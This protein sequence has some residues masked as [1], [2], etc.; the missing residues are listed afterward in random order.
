[1]YPITSYIEPK[2][3]L[4]VMLSEQFLT[5]VRKA[6][7]RVK[8]PKLNLESLSQFILA[9]P[10]RA[11]Q[12]RIVEKVEKLLALC[13]SLKCWLTNAKAIQF[14]LAD[15]TADQAAQLQ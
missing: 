15:A 5:Q 9:V 12:R 7:N 8:M 10:P 3:M 6:E 1:M 13:D 11:E 14:H 2:Y 4:L